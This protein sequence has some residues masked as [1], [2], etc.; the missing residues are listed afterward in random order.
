MYKDSKPSHYVDGTNRMLSNW[1]R[2]INC[3]CNEEQQNLVA[4]QLHGEVYY[5]AIR[6]I[7]SG[8]ELLIWYK[9]EFGVVLPLHIS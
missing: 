1:M 8:E 4:Y 7:N 3:A 9:D 6:T 5:K 2:Y